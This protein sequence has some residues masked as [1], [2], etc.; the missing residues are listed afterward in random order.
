MLLF[1]SWMRSSRAVPFSSGPAPYLSL[2]E[3]QT[4]NKQQTTNNKNNKTLPA[5]K[6]Q[7]F[8]MDETTPLIPNDVQQQ[9]QQQQQQKQL[10]PRPRPISSGSPAI[11]DDD[12]DQSR[13]VSF[14]S[15]IINNNNDNN[16][17]NDSSSSC[18]QRQRSVSEVLTE[19][20]TD[21]LT[22]VTEVLE[23]QVLP[24]KPRDTGDHN[25]KLSAL[26]LSILVFYKVSGGPFGCEPTVRA[27][28]PFVALMGF[29]LFP[30]V[31]C[32]QEVLVTAELGSAYPEPSGCKYIL[33]FV[34]LFVC[35]H[36]SPLFFT[37]HFS[38]YL[39]FILH[40]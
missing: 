5:A 8:Y 28:G 11:V 15:T 18:R 17:I 26:A 27:A 14:V 6:Q 2:L 36:F 24:V 35:H 12:D 19:V 20:L 7:Q 32:L 23:E 33:L 29:A 21:G 30:L 3:S 40:F 9:Q 25:K 39:Y 37:D 31:W 13:H 22:E 34:C 4:A 16:N 38:F 10:L 1:L